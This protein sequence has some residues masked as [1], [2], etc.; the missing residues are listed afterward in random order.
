[1]QS[2]RCRIFIGPSRRLS[3]HFQHA[4]RF[5]GDCVDIAFHTYRTFGFPSSYKLSSPRR[6]TPE[7]QPTLL[8]AFQVPTACRIAWF[9]SS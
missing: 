1:M 4:K 7:F 6:E 5:I 2:L 3:K 8:Y 9:I